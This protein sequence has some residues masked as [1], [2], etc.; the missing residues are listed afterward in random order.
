MMN[1]QQAAI[2][3]ESLSS[4][5]RLK[6]FLYLTTLGEKGMIA[7]DLAKILDIRPNNLSFHLNVLSNVGL[8]FS[9]QEGRFVRYFANLSLML[10][11]IQFLTQN[12]CREDSASSCATFCQR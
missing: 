1:E 2:L 12:C 10:D 5:I 8:I 11:V 3:F 6:I 4:P 7:G 9:T